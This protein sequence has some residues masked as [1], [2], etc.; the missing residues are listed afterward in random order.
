LKIS[1]FTPKPY[2]FRRFGKQILKSAC[3]FRPK[4]MAAKKMTNR[5]IL[6]VHWVFTAI[7][8]Y[9]IC[10]ALKFELDAFKRGDH[11]LSF[12]L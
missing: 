7:V 4:K 2:V 10:Y 9:V 11:K 5:L 8:E 1:A 3:H 6:G 12:E